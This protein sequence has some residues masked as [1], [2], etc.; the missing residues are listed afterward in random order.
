MSTMKDHF[1]ERK[2][3]QQGPI[4]TGN[5]K[6]VILISLSFILIGF[7]ASQAQEKAAAT[8]YLKVVGYIAVVHPIITFDKNGHTTNFSDSYTVGFP[9]GIH[10]FKSARFGYS[11]EVV[12]F[13][14]SADGSS[15]VNNV[16]FH[17]GLVFRFP[18]SWI[19]YTR[20]AFETSGRYG[21]TPSISK[22]VYKTKNNNFFVTVPAPLRFGNDKPVSIG[23]GLQMGLTF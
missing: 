12:P 16:L 2:A 22:V 11:L 3:G 19:L 17:P 8:S 7:T 20:M 4:R 6:Q 15:K 21:F 23:L 5:M 10:I 14:K 18:K 1:E 13:I 9:T